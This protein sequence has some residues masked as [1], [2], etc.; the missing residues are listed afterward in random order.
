MTPAQM[1][2]QLDR[3]CGAAP[4]PPARPRIKTGIEREAEDRMEEIQRE[5]LREFKE[6]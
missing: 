6:K 5:Y 2:S 1:Q 3:C 4:K